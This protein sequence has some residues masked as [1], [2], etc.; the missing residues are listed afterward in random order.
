MRV[1]F[2]IY[3]LRDKCKRIQVLRLWLQAH[4]NIDRIILI[5]RD[6]TTNSPMIHD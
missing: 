2:L 4:R 6:G 3:C 5:N 1:R